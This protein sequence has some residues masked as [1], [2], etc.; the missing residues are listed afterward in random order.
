MSDVPPGE[1]AT[2]AEV[3]PAPSQT[4]AS[5]APEPTP[6]PLLSTGPAGSGNYEVQQ[7]DCMESIALD[8]GFFWETLWNHPD[9]LDLRKARKNPNVLREGDKVFLPELRP[10]QEAG[11]TEQRHRFKRK[12]V[13]SKLRIVLRDE[14]N[15]PRVNEPYLLEIEGNFI[16]GRTGSQGEL[17]HSISPNARNGRLI[18]GQEGVEVYPLNLGHIDPIT[19]LSGIQA[20]LSNLGYYCGAIDGHMN[21]QIKQAI[22][23]FQGEHGLPKTGQAD[24]PTR[25]KLA[26]EYGC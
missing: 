13:P 8:R 24:A 12:G 5:A 26:A 18:V 3:E 7:G 14:Q 19:E 9:N 21:L 1:S 2:P 10:K 11:A 22:L 25:D 15:R 6:G 23:E 17:E 20:R 4:S 16:R